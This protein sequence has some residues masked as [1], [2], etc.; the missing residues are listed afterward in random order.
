[1]V[2]MRALKMRSV[3]TGHMKLTMTNWEVSSKLILL[4]LSEKLPK[5]STLTIL[6]YFGIWRRLERCKSLISGS[7]MSWMKKKKIIVLKWH[8]LLFCVHAK[9]TNHFSTGLW[10]ATKSGF[11]MATG[12]DQPSGWTEKKLQ[13]TFQS[14]TWTKKRSWSLFGGLLPVWSTT[15][16]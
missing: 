4:Q 2:E 3:M 6:Q 14:Q 11:Y 12:D 9:S 15:A 13:S 16:V 8:L 5:N 7:L 1:M 10:C